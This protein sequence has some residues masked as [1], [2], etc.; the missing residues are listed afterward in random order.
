MNLTFC[1]KDYKEMKK[2]HVFAS[3]ER[4]TWWTLFLSNPTFEIAQGLQLEEGPLFTK[5][6]NKI[7]FFNKT[8]YLFTQDIFSPLF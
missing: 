2:S 8:D 7:M 5:V 3:S 1:P 6:E 4:Q